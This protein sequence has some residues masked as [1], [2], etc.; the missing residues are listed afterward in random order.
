MKLICTIPTF[1]DVAKMT[2]FYCE[3]CKQAETKVA[4]LAT[5]SRE[6]SRA[7]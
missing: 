3:G 4:P 6:P 5:T 2:V 1:E 7:L